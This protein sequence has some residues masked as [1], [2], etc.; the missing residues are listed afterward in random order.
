MSPNTRGPHCILSGG[1][2]D[3][4][5]ST[6]EKPKNKHDDCAASGPGTDMFDSTRII[7]EKLYEKAK[8]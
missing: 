4:V 7:A 8:V 2:C 5:H 6:C 1:P 3:S